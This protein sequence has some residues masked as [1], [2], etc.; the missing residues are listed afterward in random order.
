MPSSHELP[1]SSRIKR[2][3]EIVFG[4]VAG[5]AVLV[6]PG[7]ARVRMLN[8]VGSRLWALAD[9]NLT[10]AQMAE[11]L[12]AEYE[13]TPAA[14]A[15]DVLR[16]AQDLLAAGLVEVTGAPPLDRPTASAG[17]LTSEP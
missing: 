9:G 3:S 1:P 17:P 8:P 14:A 15:A 12:T 6:A 10:L 16:F 4:E 7:Q 13:V 11:A 5:E 2:R